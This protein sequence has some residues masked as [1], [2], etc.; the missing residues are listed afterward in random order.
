MKK[1]GHSQ[2]LDTGKKKRFFELS[3][4]TANNYLLTYYTDVD[5][6]ITKGI[7]TITGAEITDVG[8]AAFK[9][10]ENR[11]H[12]IGKLYVLDCE[13]AEDKASWIEVLQQATK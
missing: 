8:N 3:K 1:G 4:T 2:I 5:K 10:Q 13:T 9:I 6:S 11:E 12:T 7:I